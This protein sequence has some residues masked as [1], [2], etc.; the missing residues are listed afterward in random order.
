MSEPSAPPS[1]FPGPV[2]LVVNRPWA[3]GVD[4]EVWEWMR[5]QSNVV[6]GLTAWINITFGGGGGSSGAPG[7]PGSPGAPGAPATTVDDLEVL[8]YFLSDGGV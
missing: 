3:G 6:S 2:P 1:R 8:G 7:S 5:K 4:R